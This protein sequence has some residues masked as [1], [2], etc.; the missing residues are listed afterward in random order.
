MADQTVQALAAALQGMKVS[1]RKPDLPAFD[2]KN[3]DIWLKRIDN[4]YRRAGITDAKDKF[5][6][7][8]PK[9]AVDADP[10][11][12]ELLFGEGTAEEWAEF[13]AYL[14][15]RYGR[16]KAQQAAII[17]DG[18]QREGKLPSEMF[19][20][21]KEKIGTITVD[22]IVKEMVLRELPTEI[23]RTIHDK[24]KDLNG[25]DAVKLADQYFDKTG[26]PIHK[27]A[28][29]PVNVVTNTTD[30]AVTDED[31][32]VN[33][34]GGRFARSN[35]KS[36][37]QPTQ[38]PPFRR[39]PQNS[40]PREPYNP[41]N[42]QNSRPSNPPGRPSF[43]QRRTHSGNPTVKPANLCRWHLDFGKEAFTCEEGCDKFFSHK[44]G[45]AQAGRHT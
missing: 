9:F 16:T 3:I 5:A 45:K 6:F 42:Q 20:L 37:P 36:R 25:S 44:A 8:E 33:A 15:D 13:E 31:D 2:P 10:R 18:V 12:N 11:I 38:K 7:I 30:Y 14:R 22:D 29:N 17:L 41:P 4:A 34:V 28:A 23:R 19:A 21:V 27:P 32:D 40:R 39:N 43:N 26:K 35:N 1:S 24:V